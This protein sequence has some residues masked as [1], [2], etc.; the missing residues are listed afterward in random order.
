LINIFLTLAKW[1]QKK[2]YNFIF[3]FD[4]CA[5]CKTLKKKK[6]ERS[7]GVVSLDYIHFYIGYDVKKNQKFPHNWMTNTILYTFQICKI[8]PLLKI[9]QQFV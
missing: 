3:V 1:I 7:V 8:W 2:Y 5:W 4:R 6:N 9:K